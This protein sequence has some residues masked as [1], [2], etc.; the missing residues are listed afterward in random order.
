MPVLSLPDTTYVATVR[1]E[2]ST[3]TI[4]VGI[5]GWDSGVTEL[6]EMSIEV[7][8]LLTPEEY[9]F[10]IIGTAQSTTYNISTPDSMAEK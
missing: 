7:N 10:G 9:K 4:W 6:K 2:E 1:S 8:R 3:S 5:A